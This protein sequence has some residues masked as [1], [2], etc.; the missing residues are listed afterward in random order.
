MAQNARQEPA[1]ITRPTPQL[2]AGPWLGVNYWSRR[3]GPFMWRDYDDSV[4]REELTTLRD[5]GVALTRSFLFWPDFHPAPDT[6]D[7]ECVSR[8]VRFLRTSTDVGIPTIPT[9][10]VGHMSGQEWDVPWRNGRDLYTDGFMLGQQAYY[11]REIV[12]RIGADPAVMGWLISNE[13]P[14]FAGNGSPEDVR[15]WAIV[16]TQAVRAGGSALPVSLGD[17]AWTLETTGKDN[18]FRLRQQLDLVDFVGPH[19]Y[20]MGDDQVRVHTAAAWAC[21]LSHVGKPVVMEE[22]G[23]SSSLSSE[24]NGAHFYRQVLHHCLL[25]GATGW[26]GWNNTDFDL[27]SVDPYRHR[28]FELGFGITRSDGQPKPALGE[29]AEFRGVLDAIEFGKCRRM[30]TSTAIVLPSHVEE[31]PRVPDAE[32][33]AMLAATQHAYLAAKS[34]DLAPAIVREL[35][36]PERAQLVLVPSNKMLTAP[37]FAT[38]L[39]WAEAGSHVYLSWFA[40]ASGH[41]RGAWW[42]PLEDIIGASHKLRFGMNEPVDPVVT[43]EF[44]EPFGDL[45]A[46]DKLRFGAAGNADAMAMLPLSAVSPESV[47]VAVDGRGRPALVRRD[48]GAGA[49]YLSTYPVEY[50]GSVRPDAHSDD[51]VHRLYRA[52]SARAGILPPVTVDDPRIYVDGVVH[53]SGQRFTWLVNTVEE[54]ITVRPQLRDEGIDLFDIHTGQ[55]ITNHVQLDPFGVVVAR[56]GQRH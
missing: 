19:S 27:P 39:D 26:I 16:C 21:E 47:V 45:G 22:F 36:S 5:N 51:E 32:R 37:T 56:Y 28:P 55:T 2:A 48:L 29:I 17:G 53:E 10:L 24:A 44:T 40:G 42:P 33:T 4:V 8:Y 35:D 41:H 43:W 25:A 12:R 30:D 23:V 34:A 6:I 7:D 1:Y 31:H 13:M 49:V 18:G 14:L 9:F 52:L 38:L 11:I 50:F 20:P 15:A 46:G 3:G 54:T